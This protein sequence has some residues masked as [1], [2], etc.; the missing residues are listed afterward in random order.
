MFDV[1]TGITKCFDEDFCKLFDYLLQ[2]EKLGGIKYFSGVNKS[3]RFEVVLDDAA[4]QYNCIFTLKKCMFQSTHDLGY[5][6]TV[7]SMSTILVNDPSQS[8]TK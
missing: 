5:V 4:G 2:L 8:I 6:I 3:D 1:I 7:G